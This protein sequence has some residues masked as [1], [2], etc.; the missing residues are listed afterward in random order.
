MISVPQLGLLELFCDFC[1][2]A[3]QSSFMLYGV[4]GEK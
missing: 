3:S 2:G 1:E 4:A